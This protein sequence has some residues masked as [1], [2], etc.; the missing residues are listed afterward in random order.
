MHRIS[1]TAGSI[2]V[3][4]SLPSVKRFD[5]CNSLFWFSPPPPPPSKKQTNTTTKTQQQ[6]QHITPILLSTTYRPVQ[7]KYPFYSSDLLH[8]HIPSRLPRSAFRYLLDVPR[9]RD[10]KTK[11]FGRLALTYYVAL[12]FWNV[13]PESLKEKDCIQSFRA[14]LKT[15]LCLGRIVNAIVCDVCRFAVV[16]VLSEVALP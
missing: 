13:L 6:Q 14:F 12:S 15:G 11:Q 5:Y 1:K 3:C 7:E 16:C 8:R 10:S 2:A 4:L 9:P